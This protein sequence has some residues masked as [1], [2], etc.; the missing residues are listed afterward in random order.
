MVPISIPGRSMTGADGSELTPHCVHPVLV[1]FG[2]KTRWA[3]ARD[4]I[5]DDVVH[6]SATASRSSV[7][8][9]TF[10]AKG[11]RFHYR[12]SC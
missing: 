2:Y 7:A 4:G 5:E 10:H 9:A 3:F 11:S 12:V 8:H 6:R 1:L